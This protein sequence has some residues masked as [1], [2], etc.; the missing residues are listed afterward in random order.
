MLL[1]AR[2]EINSPHPGTGFTPLMTAVSRIDLTT[3]RRLI[4]LKANVNAQNQMGR[5]ALMIATSER[6]QS[7]VE[8]LLD[9]RA[10]ATLSDRWGNTALSRASDSAIGVLL[11]QARRQCQL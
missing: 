8:W 4:D 9:A 7:V 6:M 3:T 10:D 11:E 5:T 1:T 2:A